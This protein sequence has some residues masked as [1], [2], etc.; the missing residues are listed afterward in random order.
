[1]PLKYKLGDIVKIRLSKAKLTYGQILNDASIRIFNTVSDSEVEIK[2]LEHTAIIFY[3]GVFD[4]CIVNG[5]W[6][7]AG[8]LP[9]KNEEDSWAPPK[10]IQ[11]VIHPEKFRIYHKGEMTSA[12]KEQVSGLEKQVMRKPGELIKVL[13][14][15]FK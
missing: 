12:T 8:N 11:D 7:I 4:T 9:F 2:V 5:E 6:P 10:Y 3:S 1:M 15:M 13:N 14:T